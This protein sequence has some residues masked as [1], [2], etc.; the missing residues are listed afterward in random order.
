MWASVLSSLWNSL[1]KLFISS[2]SWNF[3][4]KFWHFGQRRNRNIFSPLCVKFEKISVC[5]TW[6][7]SLIHN[8]FKISD[9]I[10][11]S[12]LHLAYRLINRAH[13]WRHEWGHMT[14]LG[15]TFWSKTHYLK[16]WPQCK[17]WSRSLY[18]I[19]LVRGQC[20]ICRPDYVF[21]KSH[22]TNLLES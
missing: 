8:I 2:S 1:Y 6:C 21:R 7:Y 4:I 17:L 19:S 13:R 14:F 22:V 5:A 12:N 15:S 3:L 11:T 10:S 20:A 9:M 18:I 16:Y